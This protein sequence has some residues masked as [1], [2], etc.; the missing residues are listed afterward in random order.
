MEI[1]NKIIPSK[2]WANEFFASNAPPPHIAEQYIIFQKSPF[3][4]VLSNFVQFD[5]I[6]TAG[7]HITT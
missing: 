4:Y 2:V 6:A 1:N 3:M 5:A 7:T